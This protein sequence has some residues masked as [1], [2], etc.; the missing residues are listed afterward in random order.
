ML[1]FVPQKSYRH[2]A[3]RES[4][5]LAQDLSYIAPF[6]VHR[7]YLMQRYIKYSKPQWNMCKICKNCTIIVAKNKKTAPNTVQEQYKGLF[8]NKISHTIITVL[9][10]TVF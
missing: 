2:P 3:L 8:S 1:L 9:Q 5:G 10:I 7:Q 4:C 6:T